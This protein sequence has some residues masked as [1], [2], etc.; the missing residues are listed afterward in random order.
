MVDSNFPICT[1]GI[2]GRDFL[3]FYKCNL[4]YD[5]WIL[6]FNYNDDEIN[7]TI[8]DNIDDGF[9]LPEQCEV[10]RRVPNSRIEEDSVV[11]SQEIQNG[12]LCGNTIVS[13][14]SSFVKFINTTNNVMLIRNFQ[15]IILLFKNYV[16]ANIEKNYK[17]NDRIPKIKEKLDLTDIPQYAKNSLEKLV[18]N[19]NDVFALGEDNLTTNNFYA[20]N[21]EL[22]DN[23]PV[24]IP[25]YRSLHAQ[26]DEIEKQVNKM[27]SN[28]IIEQS[29]SA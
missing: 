17:L 20:Q 22:T 16:I 2:L 19:Y 27:L 13:P 8:E 23:V 10:I 15:P 7:V 3:S 14:K 29:V 11:C 18:Q 21:I 12:V 26:N 6:S 9:L 28:N 25:N 5:T 1:D 24:Y 4:N